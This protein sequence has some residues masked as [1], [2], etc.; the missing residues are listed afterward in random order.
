MKCFLKVLY[1]SLDCGAFRQLF[2][3]LRLLCVAE[4]VI[5][6]HRLAGL[7]AGQGAGGA[8]AGEATGQSCSQG[9]EGR[10]GLLLRFR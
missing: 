10:D 3:S 7:G 2:I 9:S 6:H 8:V 5:L 4:V 1:M